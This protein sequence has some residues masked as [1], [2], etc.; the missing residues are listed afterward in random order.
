MAGAAAQRSAETCMLELI[1]LR[2]AWLEDE[3]PC[4]LDYRS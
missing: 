2:I 3:R 1:S 4:C